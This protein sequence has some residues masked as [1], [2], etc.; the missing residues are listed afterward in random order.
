MPFAKRLIG[1]LAV[2]LFLLLA[3]TSPGMAQ[4]SRSESLPVGATARLG[5]GTG[6]AVQYSPDGTQLAVGGSVGIWLYDVHTR[7]VVS[8]FTGHAKPVTSVAFSPD[9]RTLASNGAGHTILLW[10]VV[11][12]ILE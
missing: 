9:G 1:A 6:T 8:L 4:E 11:A 5:R 2:V 7:E 12:Y 3:L 10:N